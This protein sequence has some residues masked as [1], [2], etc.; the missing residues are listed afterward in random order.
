MINYK[1]E[2]SVNKKK[3]MWLVEDSGHSAPDFGL[4][5]NVFTFAELLQTSCTIVRI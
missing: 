5:M 4:I 1:S 2:W 3:L